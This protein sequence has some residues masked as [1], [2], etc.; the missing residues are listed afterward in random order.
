[1][2]QSG[3]VSVIMPVYNGEAYLREALDSLL[4][5]SLQDLEILAVNDASTDGSLA[6]LKEYEP[7]FS[8]KLRIYTL[9]K[10]SGAGGARNKG[11]ME[12]TG[13]YLAFFDCDDLATP[14]MYEKMLEVAKSGNYDM[15]DCGYYRQERD[16]ARLHTADE[17]TGTLNVEKKRHL[18]VGGGYLWSRLVRR[19]LFFPKGEQV[20]FR[21]KVTLEDSEILN[22]LIMAAK[23]VGSVKEILYMYRDMPNSF[24][25]VSKQDGYYKN[26]YRAMKANYELLHG[27]PDYE[28]VKDAIEYEI[29]HMYDLAV[30]ACLQGW[31]EKKGN[32]SVEEKEE[33][34]RRMCSLRD[35]K[36]KI[37]SGTYDENVYVQE[38]I[39][40]TDIQIMKWNDRDSEGLLQAV[41]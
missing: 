17:D 29:L 9:E 8:G 23:S 36:E 27:L 37:V 14:Q 30:L 25:K 19:E 32:V 26:L 21:K 11:I 13:E 35:L 40:P 31:I 34:L 20:L 22:Y 18:I 41:L 5:Q 28:G 39:T 12:S 10:N 3:R 38:K 33:L 15:V 1:M 4:A 24:S 2:V 16:E 7:K 6:I